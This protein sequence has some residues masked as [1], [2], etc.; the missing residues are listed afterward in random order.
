[1]RSK[2]VLRPAR[3][4]VI[5]EGVRRPRDLVNDPQW[6]V[7]VAQVVVVEVEAEVEARANAGEPANTSARTRGRTSRPVGCLELMVSSF[8]TP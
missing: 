1:M 5:G 2:Q 8:R 7:V 6:A 4:L 3:M